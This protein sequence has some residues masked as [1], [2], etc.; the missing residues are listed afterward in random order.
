MPLTAALLALA[1]VATPAEPPECAVY[2]AW[3]DRRRALDRF[4]RTYR[5]HPQ[6]GDEIDDWYHVEAVAEDSDPYV[7]VPSIADAVEYQ[8]RYWEIEAE[9]V[10][11]LR[12]DR[13][14]LFEPVCENR[15]PINSYSCEEDALNEVLT[16]VSERVNG[17]TPPP[18]LEFIEVPLSA[19]LAMLEWRDQVPIECNWSAIAD[20]PIE[21]D[22]DGDRWAFSR[23]AYSDDGNFALVYV[24]NWWGGWVGTGSF[25][26]FE[27][28]EGEWAMVGA[29]R[30]WIR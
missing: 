27:R 10:T 26:L 25:E 5:L 24:Q 29:G 2:Q 18:E 1:Q 16:I 11:E 22:R 8:T 3:F 19:R 21:I 20:G 4:E 7:R 13:P 6:A 23:V 15:D 28:S 17:T 9:V 14:E 12:R 30:E